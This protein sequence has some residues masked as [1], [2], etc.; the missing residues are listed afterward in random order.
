MSSD[1]IAEDEIESNLVG[2]NE[3][4]PDDEDVDDIED[5]EQDDEPEPV[6]VKKK[7]P[8]PKA[9]KTKTPSI[10]AP[11]VKPAPVK[12]KLI[13]RPTAD[14]T[15]ID[16]LKKDDIKLAAAYL[17]LASDATRLKV[18][19]LVD[20]EKTVTDLTALAKMSQPA[21]SHHL[22]LLRSSRCVTAERAGKN[23]LYSLTKPGKTLLKAI[24]IIADSV[25]SS[26]DDDE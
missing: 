8:K 21:L 4:Q 16:G 12:A 23:N 11:K 5:D 2:E 24:K 13:A 3:E 18:L 7:G 25:R 19:A 20:G 10:P 17:K 14:G 15:I 22:S 26:E 9:V 1:T 6:S